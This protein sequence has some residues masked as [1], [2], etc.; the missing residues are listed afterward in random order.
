LFDSLQFLLYVFSFVFGFVFSLMEGLMKWEA[1]II[2]VVGYLARLQSKEADMLYQFLLFV[3]YRGGRGT[4][5]DDAGNK[6]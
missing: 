6:S 1:N 5:W 2:Q 4:S 3:Y